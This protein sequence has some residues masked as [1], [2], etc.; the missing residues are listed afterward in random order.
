MAIAMTYL[1][2]Q[3]SLPVKPSYLILFFPVTTTNTKNPTFTTFKD[4]PYLTEA[5]LDWMYDAF[6][7]NSSDRSLPTTSPLYAM[8]D[9]DLKLF[10]PTLVVP[11]GVDPLRDEGEMFGHRLQ[12]L[13][14]ETAVLRAD[15][16]VHDFVM[17]QPTRV[18]ATCRAVV[19]LA[20]LKVK[21]ALF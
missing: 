10:P 7:P 4:G 1:S 13:G 17:L 14:V 20:A 15:G 2:H 12:G 5:I 6:V 16:Q 8:P 19:E 9:E 3:R 18:S 11:A 21:K